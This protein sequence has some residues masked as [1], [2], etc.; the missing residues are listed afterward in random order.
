[1]AGDE[2]TEADSVGTRFDRT[3][4]IVFLG[5]DVLRSMAEAGR[6]G[7][8]GRPA[9][10]EVTLG[11]DTPVGDALW[12]RDGGAGGAL[13]FVISAPAYN[14]INIIIHTYQSRD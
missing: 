8:G 12:V 11:C 5:G 6:T 10:G 14:R 13:D 7:G 3:R 9:P 2:G 4:I 1:M